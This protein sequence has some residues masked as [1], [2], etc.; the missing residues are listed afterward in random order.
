MLIR[1]LDYAGEST[2]VDIGD[3]STINHIDLDVIT[4][5]EI[6]IVEYKNGEIKT[7]DSASDR[8]ADYFDNSYTVY[9]NSIDLLKDDLWLARK[10]SYDW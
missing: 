10:S 6:L 7:F 3:L 2:Q 9:S 4:G 8:C 5:D 1:I